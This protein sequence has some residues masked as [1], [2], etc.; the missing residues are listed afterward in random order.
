M[1]AFNSMLFKFYLDFKILKMWTSFFFQ[2]IMIIIIIILKSLFTYS[3]SRPNNLLNS[4]NFM[5]K[6]C[7]NTDYKKIKFENLK[8][9]MWITKGIT[10]I[11]K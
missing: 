5:H 1:P 3:N 6:Y 2:K 7:S 4:S 10:K 9:T 11:R 8:L